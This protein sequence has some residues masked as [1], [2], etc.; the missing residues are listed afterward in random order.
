MNL[1][2]NSENVTIK[3]LAYVIFPL[4]IVFSINWCIFETIS[5]D[6]IDSYVM[7]E[8]LNIPQSFLDLGKAVLSKKA[9]S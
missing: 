3:W 4:M 7:L 9:F 5:L 1:G 8:K 2:T 6:S